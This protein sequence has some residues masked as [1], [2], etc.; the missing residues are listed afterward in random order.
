MELRAE[1][2]P[3]LNTVTAYGNGY[4]EINEEKYHHAIY[5]G[6][7]GDVR[8]WDVQ[9][10]SDITPAQLKQVA[11]VNKKALDPLAFLDGGSA[12][13]DPEQTEVIIVGTGNQHNLLPS[14]ITAE[15]QT[16][17]IGIEAMSTRAAARTYN[18]LMAEGRRVIAALLPLEPIK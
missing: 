5:F 12:A 11:G 7:E 4:I 9:T 3:S 6:P 15:L 16:S 8:Q 17:G 1:T 2:N 14:H 13:P 10:F 18:I